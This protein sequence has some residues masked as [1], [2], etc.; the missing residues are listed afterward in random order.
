VTHHPGQEQQVGPPLATPAATR[1]YPVGSLK[2]NPG[3][4][5]VAL[6]T[7]IPADSGFAWAVVRISHGATSQAV[8]LFGTGHALVRWDRWPRSRARGP[9]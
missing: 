7:T 5:A 8:P 3:T 1:S 9:T 2:R 4:M 6:R